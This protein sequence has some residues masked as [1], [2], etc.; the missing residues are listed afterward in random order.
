M[1]RNISATSDALALRSATLLRSTI[2]AIAIMAVAVL[3]SLG[4]TGEPLNVLP[5][6]LSLRGTTRT[7]MERATDKSLTGCPERS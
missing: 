5:P 3:S 4:M 2:P 7:L 1:P 6:P